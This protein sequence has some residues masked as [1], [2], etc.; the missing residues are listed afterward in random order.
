MGGEERKREPTVHSL[1]LLLVD[2]V[3]LRDEE[4]EFMVWTGDRSDLVVLVE[5]VAT[6][7]SEVGFWG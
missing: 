7:A 4:V 1:A 5:V 2:A 3:I 6:M